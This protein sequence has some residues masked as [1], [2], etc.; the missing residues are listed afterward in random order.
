MS[1]GALDQPAAHRPPAYEQAQ[2]RAARLAQT[3]TAKV[4]LQLMN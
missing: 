3:R 2:E 1:E 4:V